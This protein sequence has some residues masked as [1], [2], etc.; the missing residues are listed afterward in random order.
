MLPAPPQR[1]NDQI[2][3]LQPTSNTVLD[4]VLRHKEEEFKV[5]QTKVT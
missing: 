2:D 4:A 1:E 3:L 5:I